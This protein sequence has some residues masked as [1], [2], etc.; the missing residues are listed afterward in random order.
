M[1]KTKGELRVERFIVPYRVYGDGDIAIVCVSGAQQTMA[2]WRPFVTR[3]AREHAV[4]VFDPPGLGRSQ[5]LGGDAQVSLS[6]QV[7]VLHR[8]VTAG[9][10][11][12]TRVLC[13]ASW[14]T[15]VASAY[16][17]RHPHEVHRMILG[18]FGLKPNEKLRQIIDTGRRLYEDSEVDRAGHLI[19]E[20]FGQ[21]I[22]GPRREHIV[23]QFEELSREQARTLY[24]HLE[25]VGACGSV[26]DMVDLSAIR[27]ATLVVNGAEDP[28]V[29]PEDAYPAAARIANAWPLVVE[30]A[31]HFL[32][33]ERPELIEVY[34]EFIQSRGRWTPG[35]KR[36]REPS[37]AV[38]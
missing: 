26:E 4:V 10:G 25:F 27:A 14:G 11:S 31:G 20:G 32:H 12:R 36:A 30:D 35:R 1:K 19:V 29:D 28:I 34:A 9:A 5:I 38:A 24:H 37:R 22:G 13:A 8:I 17:A 21:R 6:E 18:S 16:A 7:R 33:L 23:R 3:F 15:I 2:A